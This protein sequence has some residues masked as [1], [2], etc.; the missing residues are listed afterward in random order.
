MDV[1][2][3]L[4]AWNQRVFLFFFFSFLSFFYLFFLFL[5]G[6]FLHSDLRVYLIKHG[7]V[8]VLSSRLA[9][10]SPFVCSAP[11]FFFFFFFFRPSSF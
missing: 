10:P 11:F 9:D 7:I 6:S 1:T 4:S 3:S 8:N 5:V 2:P